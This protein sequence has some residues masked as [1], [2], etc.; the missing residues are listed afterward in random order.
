MDEYQQ[1]LDGLEKPPT[2]GAISSAITSMFAVLEQRGG[3]TPVEEAKRAILVKVAHSVDEGLAAPKLSVA[4][5]NLVTKMLDTL[6][7][8]SG[9]QPDQDEMDAWDAT[10]IDITRRQT[11]QAT[12]A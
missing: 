8:M 7:T 4:T 1:A 10:V 9:I 5:A 11:M 12:G 2:D 3:L 6:D